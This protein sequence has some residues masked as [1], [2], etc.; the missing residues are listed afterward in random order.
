MRTYAVGYDWYQG[1]DENRHGF[2]SSYIVLQ[3]IEEENTAFKDC[4]NNHSI[5]SLGYLCCSRRRGYTPLS[6]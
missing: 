3:S 5:P 2:E 6:R 1:L 4:S